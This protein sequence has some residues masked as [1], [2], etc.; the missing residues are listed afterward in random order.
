MGTI[1]L[2]GTPWGSWPLLSVQRTSAHCSWQDGLPAQ[3]GGCA[4]RPGDTSQECPRTVRSEGVGEHSGQ[5]RP[6]ECK[7]RPAPGA[8]GKTSAQVV[9]WI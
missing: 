9:C 6:E 2:A 4:F 7:H 8:A 3:V 1:I 5:A